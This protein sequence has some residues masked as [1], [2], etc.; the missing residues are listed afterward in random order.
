MDEIILY[1]MYHKIGLWDLFWTMFCLSL[2]GYFGFN[3][4]RYLD[5]QKAQRWERIR[6]MRIPDEKTQD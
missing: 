4:A 2:I 6:R 5:E 1:I 3:L